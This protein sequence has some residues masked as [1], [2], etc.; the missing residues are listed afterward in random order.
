MA[1]KYLTINEGDGHNRIYSVNFSE[2][3]NQ[4]ISSVLKG[5][6]PSIGKLK[7]NG[8]ENNCYLTN[9]RYLSLPYSGL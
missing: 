6:K 1:A 8:F 3:G 2:N 4:I 7:N 9:I 5:F